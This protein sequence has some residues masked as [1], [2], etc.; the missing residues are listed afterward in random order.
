VSENWVVK[1]QAHSFR[2]GPGFHINLTHC[3]AHTHQRRAPAI[4]AQVDERIAV[5]EKRHGGVLVLGSVF[6]VSLPLVT[7]AAGWTPPRAHPPTQGS[8]AL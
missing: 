1:S 5:R 6:S 4:L 7:E 3:T 2:Y 8:N